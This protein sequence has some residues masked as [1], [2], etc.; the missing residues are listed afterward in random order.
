LNLTASEREKISSISTR[1]KLGAYTNDNWTPAHMNILRAAA[2]DD[3]TARIFVFPGAKI[4]MCDAE[5]DD[6]SWLNKIRP[7]WGHHYHFHVRL[8]CP[9]SDAACVNQPTPPKGDGCDD[10]RKWVRDIL[11][12]PTPDPNAPPTTKRRELTLSDLPVQCTAVLR[13]G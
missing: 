11:D 3:R 2:K 10:A 13:A 8:K 6:R 9:K 12:P 5:T 7:W 4:A 1:R